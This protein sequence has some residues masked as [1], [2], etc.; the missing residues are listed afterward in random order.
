MLVLTSALRRFFAQES[1]GGV[2]MLL[3][4]AAA[5]I[6]ANTAGYA[7]YKAFINSDIGLSFA[8]VQTAQPLK[9]WVKDVPMVLFFLVVGLE[10]KRELSSGFLSKRSDILM[11]LACAAAGM[12]L[13]A[14]F[15]SGIVAG[16]PGLAHGW[17]IP[18]ATDIAFALCV[19]LL[20]GRGIPP[21]AKI[22]LLAIAIFDDLGAILVV[23]LFYSG[24]VDMGALALAGLGVLALYA[25]NK[26]DSR[27][28]TPRLLIGVYLWFCFSASGIHTTVA[29]VVLGMM[30]P[31]RCDGDTHHSPL[32]KC[33]HFL[34]PWVSFLV[35]PLFAFASAG[36]SFSGLQFSDLLAPLPLGIAAALFFGKQLGILGTAWLLVKTGL[37]KRPEQTTWIQIYGISIIAGIGFTMSLFIGGLAFTEDMQDKVKLGVIAGSLASAV[38]GAAVLGIAGRR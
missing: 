38:W 24:G 9:T 33:L 22:F 8:G 26:A 12:A 14:L 28:L 31:M 20:V 11:P 2:I 4:A 6:L 37:A 17:A 27:M 30:M 18:A 16:E 15:Y 34:H 23:A 13:P 3:A 36:I 25:L 1:A 32:N 29:G 19:L 7:W 21:A 10:L 35:L 5:L